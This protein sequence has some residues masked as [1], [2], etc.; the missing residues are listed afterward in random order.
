M[1]SR[2]FLID[3]WGELTNMRDLSP[4]PADLIPLKQHEK[5]TELQKVLLKIFL[6][7]FSTKKFLVKTIKLL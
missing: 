2:Y 3:I 5:I 6:W 1:K 4:I 7:K